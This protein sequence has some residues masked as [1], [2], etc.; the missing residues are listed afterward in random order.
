MVSFA[1]LYT[2]VTNDYVV[3][4]RGHRYYVPRASPGSQTCLISKNDYFLRIP[5]GIFWNPCDN[6]WVL[7]PFWW[8]WGVQR[9]RTHPLYAP[10]PLLLTV[11]TFFHILLHLQIYISIIL[12]LHYFLFISFIGLLS[13]SSF[14]AV[15]KRKGKPMVLISDGSSEPVATGLFLKILIKIYDLSMLTNALNRLYS[16][17]DGNSVMST[18]RNLFR[19]EA[20]A[21]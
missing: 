11:L 8:L 13:L 5:G 16:L 1:Y 14:V 6:R 19:S 17:A 9:D 2:G 3:F 15:G 18:Y 20:V 7:G 12:Y 10:L 4:H 21:N